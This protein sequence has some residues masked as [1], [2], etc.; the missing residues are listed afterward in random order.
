MPR[1]KFRKIWSWRNEGRSKKS[2]RLNPASRWAFRCKHN[3]RENKHSIIA[4]ETAK[5]TLAR[6]GGQWRGRVK[7]ADDF[8]VL[9]ESF[10]QHF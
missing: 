3:K 5:L 10:I 6:R 8:D 1:K 7:I 2:G 4:E 9:P